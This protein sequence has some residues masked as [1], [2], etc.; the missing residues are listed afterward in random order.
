[1]KKMFILGFPIIFLVLIAMFI[2]VTTQIGSRSVEI[3]TWI[4]TGATVMYVFAT[5]L[6]WWNQ[7]KFMQ[8]ERISKAVDFLDKKE[9][10]DARGEIIKMTS[11]LTSSVDVE[12]LSL[13]QKLIVEI[14]LNSFNKA[15]GLPLEWGFLTKK[16]VSLVYNPKTLQCIWKVVKPYVDQRRNKVR[17]YMETLEKAIE[18]IN[19]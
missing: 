16:Q 8:E 12:K 6:L 1:M 11:E 9:I 18:K 19:K 4:M 17:N 5:I 10:K 15:I 2:Y 7:I 13:D 14:V 3:A